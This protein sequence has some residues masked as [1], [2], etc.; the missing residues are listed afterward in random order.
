[1]DITIYYTEIMNIISPILVLSGMLAL[2]IAI[3]VMLVNMIID[4]FTGRGFRI[5]RE[6]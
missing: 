1:M 3:I 6:K 5:G 2:T 4:A